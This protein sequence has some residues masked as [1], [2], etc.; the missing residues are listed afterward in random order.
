MMWAAKKEASGEWPCL[1]ASGTQVHVLLQR[2]SGGLV[3]K[4]RLRSI[5][6][7]TPYAFKV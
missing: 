1:I 6:R 7:K 2:L 4:P 5:G 3:P